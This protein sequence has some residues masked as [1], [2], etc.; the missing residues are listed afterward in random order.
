MDDLGV[1]VPITIG[2]TLGAKGDMDDSGGPSG[3]YS[4][5]DNFD[6]GPFEAA[7]TNPTGYLA[8]YPTMTEAARVYR[9]DI[10]NDSVFDN[11][12]IGP[13]E[14]YVVNA[15]G[16]AVPEPSTFVLLALG[17]LGLAVVRRRRAK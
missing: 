1:G 11:F 3:T 16:A 12:D 5:V 2:P 13:F 6:I 14:N 7:L 10:N 4:D 17:G 15:P 8:A 9:G